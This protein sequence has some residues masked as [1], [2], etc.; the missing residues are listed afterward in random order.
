MKRV[1]SEHAI[2]CSTEKA[3]KRAVAQIEELARE[4]GATI[5]MHEFN[6]AREI[7]LELCFGPYACMMHFDGDCRA[8]SFM[9]HWHTGSRDARYPETFWRVGSLN[10]YHFGKATTIEDTFAGFLDKLRA[11][12]AILKQ[13]E[14]VPAC[15]PEGVFA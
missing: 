12:L 2:C 14:A 15:E 13:I 10:T 9:G 3:R 7:G 5:E 4:C 8:G 6:G 1:Q 11:G